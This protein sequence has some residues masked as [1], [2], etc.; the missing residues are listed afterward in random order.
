MR[1]HTDFTNKEYVL[2]GAYETLIDEDG[3]FKVFMK[4]SVKLEKPSDFGAYK[5]IA[6]NALGSSEEIV[7]ILRKFNGI[8]PCCFSIRSCKWNSCARRLE[9]VG[10]SIANHSLRVCEV[11]SLIRL[12]FQSRSIMPHSTLNSRP[13]VDEKK[14]SFQT[15]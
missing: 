12:A 4:L 13:M 5:C 10:R 11:D 3:I 1:G 2:G 15:H 14:S 9:S 8:L 7:R 6:K